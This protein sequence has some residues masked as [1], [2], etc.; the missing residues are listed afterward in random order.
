MCGANRPLRKAA[1]EPAASRIAGKRIADL[2][3]R[4]PAGGHREA[5]IRGLL[6]AGMGREAVDER[7]FEAVRRIRRE[8]G[9][10][11]LAGFKAL[12][13]EQFNMLLV[14]TEAALAAIPSML[15]ADA[16]LRQEAFELIN[17]VLEARGELSAEDQE[18]LQ[19][20]K[21]LF[22]EDAGANRTPFRQNR[23]ELQAKAL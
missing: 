3:A 12:V 6:Y 2:K 17:R 16:K 10:V 22:T 8:H 11:P 5:T 7:G 14:D 20:V 9:D 21:R 23:K 19:R 15:P 18:R 4:I 13:R 1:E